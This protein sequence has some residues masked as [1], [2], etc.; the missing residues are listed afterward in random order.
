MNE[1]IIEQ[2]KYKIEKM[3]FGG[4]G[5]GVGEDGKKVFLWNSLPGE[6]VQATLGKNKK[7]H[8]EGIATEIEDVHESRIAPR[9]ESYLATSP[10]QMMNFR[11]EQLQKRLVLQE[12]FDR[13][14]IELTV[15]LIK[16]DDQSL[17]YRCKFEYSWYGDDDGL[18]LALFNRGTHQKFIVDGS[19]IARPEIDL[20]VRKIRDRLNGMNFRAGDLKT[21]IARTTQ[22]GEVVA[23]LF[24][25]TKDACKRLHIIQDLIGVHLKGLAIYHSNPK[26]P[27][28]VPTELI[29]TFGDISM[30]DQLLGRNI[31]YDI[32]SFFQ[33]NLPVFEIAVGDISGH[34]TAEDDV[35]DM[36]CGVGSIGLALPSVKTLKLIELD[37]VGAAM[38][39][40]NAR[41]IG[42]SAEVLHLPG[43]KALD[44]IQ[45]DSVL[46]VDPPRAGLHA[47]LTAKICEVKPKKVIYL[48]CNTSTQARDVKLMLAAGYKIIDNQ[49]YNFFPRTP[50]VETLIV[51]ERI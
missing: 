16:T 38:A 42:V 50:H 44:L 34:I 45:L 12:L 20:A 14:G 21:V 18:H 5:L 6:T 46:I 25:K 41:N 1:E 17:E 23:A 31:S 10:W 2:K 7:S 29:Y 36:F 37:P 8:G 30:V 48:S 11:E 9:D 47:K 26:S 39:K 22:D 28:S 19:A 4:Q 32:L 27:A 35:I 49:A 43:E 15:P 33:I 13:E 40:I 24:V 51:L 3:V